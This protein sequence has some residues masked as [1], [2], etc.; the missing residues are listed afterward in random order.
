MSEIEM[1]APG[2][3]SEGGG[4]EE[5]MVVVTTPPPPPPPVEGASMNDLKPIVVAIYPRFPISAE[6]ADQVRAVAQPVLDS[7]ALQLRGIISEQEG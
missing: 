1:K 5:E 4:I 2:G 6:V 7:L 3:V